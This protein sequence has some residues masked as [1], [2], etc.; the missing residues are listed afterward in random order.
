MGSRIPLAR[1][2][3]LVSRPRLALSTTPRQL[4]LVLDDVRLHGMT[5]AERRTA[6]KALAQLLLAA[7]GTATEE[8]GDDRA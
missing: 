1:A 3:Q 4:D 5:P 2:T 8:V 6:L 7:S